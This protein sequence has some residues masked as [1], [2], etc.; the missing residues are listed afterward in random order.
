MISL[1]RLVKSFIYAGRG[2]VKVIK[3]EQNFKIE[4]FA[5]LLAMVAAVVLRVSALALAILILVI[6]LVL[7]MEIINSAIEA[8]SDA[9]KPKLDNYVKRIKD[10]VAAGVMVSAL[11]A[12]AVGYFIF[13]QYFFH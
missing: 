5:G 3:E 12:L 10:I 9:L 6:G 1:R 11:T 2:L 7:I 13:S 4:L 8:V